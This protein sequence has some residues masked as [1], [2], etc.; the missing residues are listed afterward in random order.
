MLRVRHPVERHVIEQFGAQRQKDRDLRSD[1]HWRGFRLLQAFADT[2]TVFDDLACVFVQTCAEAGECLQF[3]ELCVSEFQV[4]G[5][6]AVCRPLR[7]A[8][9][10][11]NGLAHIHRGQHSQLEQ[12]W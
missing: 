6:R 2:L 12:R 5:H 8:T 10:A 4:A 7:L 3:E 9:N 11:R 1:C